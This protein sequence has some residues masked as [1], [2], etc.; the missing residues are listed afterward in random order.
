MK[1]IYVSIIALALIS[2]S[3]CKKFLEQPPD[4]RTEVNTVEKVAE[5]LTSAYP[6][7]NYIPFTESASDN[8]EDKGPTVGREPREVVMPF[9]WKDNDDRGRDTPTFYWNSC[10][11]AIAAANAALVAIDKASDQT[12]YLPYKGEALVARAYAHFMLV[13]LFAKGYDP[14]TADSSPG[15]PYVTEPEKVVSAKYT[16][17]TVASVYAAI[18]KDLLAGLPLLKNSA[19]K[20]PKYHFNVAA[21]NAF[22]ARFFLFKKEYEKVIK[23]VDAV[24]SGNSFAPLIRPWNT[25]YKTNTFEE[26][27]IK[28]TQATQ[29]P[30]LLLIETASLWARTNN[31]R[32][33]FGQELTNQMFANNVTGARWA[34]K[35]AYTSVPHYSTLKWNEYFVKTSQNA[36][37]GFPYT[38]VPV[39]TA[40]EALLNRAEAYAQI[41]NFNAAL[42]DLNTFCSTRILDYNAAA[43]AV[44][45]EKIKDY[46][47]LADPKAGLI[48]TVLD[49][50]KKEFTQEGLRWFDIIRHKIPVK[51][52]VYAIN[53]SF[54][55]I[56]LPA[57]DPRR[58]FQ[59]PTQVSLSGIQQNP[60]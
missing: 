33:G 29:V 35:S 41:G 4:Q 20:V 7:A 31:P 26:Q 16:R 51:H 2:I 21:A 28:F 19:Y 42:A 34:Y 44:T 30:T 37:I 60:R 9:Y 32:Y 48:A 8:A 10:Y 53:G 43:Y 1:K 15:I 47:G 36:T 25:I 50:K 46:Y 27:E 17:G 23:Y 55:T 5:L 18:E 57:D 6:E 59:L 13:T 38:I 3:G 24:S 49:F 58:L 14:A 52:K 22:A 12:P 45:L 56:E 11:E 39:F 54:T 40:D